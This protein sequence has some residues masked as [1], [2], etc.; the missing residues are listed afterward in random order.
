VSN[1]NAKIP[2]KDLYFVAVKLFL[3]RDNKLLITHDIYGSWDLPGGRIRRDE[4]NK[5]LAAVIKRKVLEELGPAVQYELG[6]PKVFFRVQ[7]NEYD[8]GGQ[9]VRIFAVGYN[10]KLVS[11]KIR[12]GDHHDQM[13]WVD[14]KSFKPEEYFADGWLSGVKEYLAEQ[15]SI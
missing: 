6:A 9:P 10:A 8:L 11:G 12:L 4:F 1:P 5:P 13:E 14:I 7:R 15:K 3:V 2:E